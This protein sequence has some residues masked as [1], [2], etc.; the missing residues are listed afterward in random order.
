MLLPTKTNKITET[1]YVFI[2]FMVPKINFFEWSSLFWAILFVIIIKMAFWLWI[3]HFNVSSLDHTINRIGLWQVNLSAKGTS[4]CSNR[5]VYDKLIVQNNS[6][7]KRSYFALLNHLGGFAAAAWQMPVIKNSQKSMSKSA[8]SPRAKFILP[9]LEKNES[10]VYLLDHQ[11]FAM[12]TKQKEKDN[13]PTIDVSAIDTI[14]K[15]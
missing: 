4:E 12:I 1:S 14:K 6:K 8:Y 7:H 15:S 5:A 13:Y 2:I 9:H 11:I 3:V 10:I